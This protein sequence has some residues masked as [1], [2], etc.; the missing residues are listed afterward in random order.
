M[1]V[2]AAAGH[3]LPGMTGPDVRVDAWANNLGLAVLMPASSN[4]QGLGGR[5]GQG[6][7][8]QDLRHPRAPAPAYGLREEEARVCDVCVAFHV[9]ILIF[10]HPR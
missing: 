6:P 10:V 8:R 5:Q 4:S 2:D 7:L 3:G 1:A 9:L